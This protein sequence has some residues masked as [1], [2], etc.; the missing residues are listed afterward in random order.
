MLVVRMQNDL[1][2]LNEVFVVGMQTHL[3][4]TVLGVS[5]EDAD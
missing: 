4:F 1:S 3:W 5:G 2:F